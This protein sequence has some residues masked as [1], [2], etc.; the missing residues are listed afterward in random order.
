MNDTP[1]F[2]KVDADQ[3]LKRAAEIE[4]L[5]DSRRFSIDDLRLIAGEAG[6]GAGAVERAIG[7]AHGAAVAELNRPPV[8][9]WGLVITH[10]STTRE[11]PVG[12]NAEQLM[13]VVRLLQ[14]YREGAARLE[15]DEHE[16]TWTD[17][18]GL[19]FAVSSSGGVTEVRV[20]LS[21]L[22]LRK[23]RWKEWVRSAADRLEVL[24]RLVA[25]QEQTSTPAPRGRLPAYQSPEG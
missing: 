20:F 9:K 19:R 2:S 4:G 12:I 18:R 8:Q 6:F 10:L 3:I 15:L 11:I 17:R 25:G 14:P 13:T 1:T 21:R 5:E 7:E 24:V 16:I 23:G 22:I